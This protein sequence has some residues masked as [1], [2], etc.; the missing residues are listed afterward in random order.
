MGRC[1]LTYIAVQVTSLLS[2][3]RKYHLL[4]CNYCVLLVTRSASFYVYR[5]FRKRCR[6][7]SKEILFS[8]KN[9]IIVNE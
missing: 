2:M 4:M 1:T 8:I 3:A 5:A 9:I 6:I 7:I